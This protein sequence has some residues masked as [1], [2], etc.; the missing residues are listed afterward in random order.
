MKLTNLILYN[1]RQSPSSDEL[2]TSGTAPGFSTVYKPKK[3][4][5]RLN[6]Q[7]AK[8]PVTDCFYTQVCAPS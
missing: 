7:S 1:C 3:G 6:E 5:L 4:G 8:K 2:V